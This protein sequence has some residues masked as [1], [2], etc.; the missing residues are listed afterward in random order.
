[1]LSWRWKPIY[2]NPH[3][4]T[5]RLFDRIEVLATLAIDPVRPQLTDERGLRLLAVIN[6]YP[7]RGSSDEQEPHSKPRKRSL[8]E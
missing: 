3:R 2:V 8:L 4:L 6:P 7:F 5:R 1:M